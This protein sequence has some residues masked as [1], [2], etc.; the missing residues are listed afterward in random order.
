MKPT[1]KLLTTGVFMWHAEER[2]S[3]RYGAFYPATESY[4]G[5]MTKL[6]RIDQG[7][8]KGFDGKRVRM[9]AVV[10]ESRPS[11]HL[12][13]F[14]LGLRP[15]PAPVG[16][17][18]EIGVGTLRVT[19]NPEI[20]D[21][22]IFEL[23]PDDGRREFWCDPRNFYKLHDQTVEFYAARTKA[24]APP[25]YQGSRDEDEAIVIGTD[26]AGAD[27]QVKTRSKSFR[28]PGTI[29]NM[30]GGTFIV[31]APVLSEGSRHKL[32]PE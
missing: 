13:D 28:I 14:F 23:H 2:R 6:R 8:V 25:A 5:E 26:P 16:A 30:G 3:N 1:P 18:V 31:R 19:K 7:A 27:L 15:N 20:G 22:P 21:T 17:T 9:F 12:G 24:A 32:A 10:V 11:G 29:A 4:S